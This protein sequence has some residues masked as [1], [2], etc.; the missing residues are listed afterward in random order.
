MTNEPEWFEV[1]VSRFPKTDETIK[2]EGDG[3]VLG[4]CDVGVSCSR[5]ERTVLERS[6]CLEDGGEEG[7]EGF[8]LDILEDSALDAEECEGVGGVEGRVDD[9]DGP[10]VR[11]GRST[12]QEN[13]EGAFSAEVFDE[14]GEEAVDDKGLVAVAH[15]VEEKGGVE[16]VEGDD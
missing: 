1:V 4:G 3:E 7:E 13:D 2:T 11:D 14:E 12:V 10:G 8:D 9:G 16:G 15:E 6:G 5:F